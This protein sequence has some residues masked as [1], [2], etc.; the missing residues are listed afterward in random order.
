MNNQSVYERITR[1][2]LGKLQSGVIPWKATWR[3]AGLPL[4]AVS[5]KPY[6][7]V[8]ILMLASEQYDSPFWMT[9]KQARELGGCVRSGE[10][11]VPVIFWKWLERV[12]EETGDKIKIPLL[13]HYIVFN[14]LQCDGL[15]LEGRGEVGTGID[16]CDEIVS[17][18]LSR[19]PGLTLQNTKSYPFYLPATDLVNVPAITS[20]ESAEDYYNT[21]FHELTHSTGHRD[22]LDRGLSKPSGFAS[23]KY[24]KEELVAELG[25]SFL[26]GIAGIENQTIEDSAGYIWGW[27]RALEKDATLLVHA[28]AQAQRAVD[29]ILKGS[30]DDKE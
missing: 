10:N 18:Y 22:R 28:G 19:E 30:T 3:G 17:S 9:Y 27:M 11:G 15:N 26:S 24:S 1:R 2:I 16:S 29:Y 20:F 14:A 7:G 13:K 25:A 4:N 8:N 21:L 12:E 6:R 5:K 23:E